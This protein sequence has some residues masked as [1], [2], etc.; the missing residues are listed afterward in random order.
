[1]RRPVPQYIVK[2]V[3]RATRTQVGGLMV[4]TAPWTEAD[5]LDW[6]RRQVVLSVSRGRFALPSQERLLKA[7]GIDV[8]PATRAEIEAVLASAVREAAMIREIFGELAAIIQRNEAAL[9]VTA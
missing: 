1:M 9:A 7:E 3:S 6:Y 4:V 2:V 8:V 5:A